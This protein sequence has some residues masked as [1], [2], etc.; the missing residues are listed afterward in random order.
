MANLPGISATLDRQQ[1]ER[2]IAVSRR[3]WRE[4]ISRAYSFLTS[5]KP[6]NTK[7]SLTQKWFSQKIGR[8]V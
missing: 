3:T 6:L 1:L 5:Q 4:D 7:A 8:F 2:A